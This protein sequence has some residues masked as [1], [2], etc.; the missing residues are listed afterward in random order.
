V[1]A[2][3]L[4]GLSAWAFVPYITYRIAP[5]A[6]VNAELLRVAAPIAGQLTQSLPHKGDFVPAPVTVSLITSF[7]PDRRRL[8]DLDRELAVSEQHAALARKQLDEIVAADA[9]LE[10]RADAHRNWNA[11]TC[12]I[13]SSGTVTWCDG[14]NWK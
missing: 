14:K 4:V 2:L 7:S 10:K 9:E 13:P 6:F 5:S 1:L 12:P 8:L 3:T 11:M